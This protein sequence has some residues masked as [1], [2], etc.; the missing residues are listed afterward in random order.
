MEG[1]QAEDLG[2][3]KQV[4]LVTLPHPR[5]AWPD[6]DRDSEGFRCPGS[7]RRDEIINIF[8]D[9]FARPEYADIGNQHKGTK[10]ALEKMVVFRELH[11]PTEAGERCAHYHVALCGSRTF[12]FLPYKRALRVRFKLASHWS[13][14]HDGYW[15]VVRYG[16]M[17]TP[18]KPQAELDDKYVAWTQVGKH[19]PLVEECQEPWSSSALKRR[20]EHAAKEKSEQGK[21][22]PRASDPWR[23]L[24]ISFFI[25][26]W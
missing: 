16:F 17:P 22:E 11:Q 24:V 21:A 5:A 20:R 9:I 2:K 13:C 3:R 26:I 1:L 7:L 15:S 18:R 12:R 4:Y 10:L 6:R 23:R 25:I 8:K 19:R 14:S